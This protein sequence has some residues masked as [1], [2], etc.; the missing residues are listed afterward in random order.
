M[1]SRPDKPKE[2]MGPWRLETGT[3]KSSEI[4]VIKGGDVRVS[5]PEKMDGD[6]FAKMP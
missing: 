5:L 3:P 6:F 2:K 1:G 4:F